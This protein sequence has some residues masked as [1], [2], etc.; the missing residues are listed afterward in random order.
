M[1]TNVF[2]DAAALEGPEELIRVLTQLSNC[3]S[4]LDHQGNFLV[5]YDGYVNSTNTVETYQG[6]NTGDPSAGEWD[7]PANFPNA[8]GVFVNPAAV[9]VV[10]DNEKFRIEGVAINVQGVWL[11]RPSPAQDQ[12]TFKITTLSPGDMAARGVIVGGNILNLQGQF[13][14]VGNV[15]VW[16][17]NGVAGDNLVSIGDQQ[18]TLDDS[19]TAPRV[20]GC[21]DPYA[22]DLV[23]TA[24]RLSYDG[25]VLDLRA[26]FT[27]AMRLKPIFDTS[28]AILHYLSYRETTAPSTVYGIRLTGEVALSGSTLKVRFTFGAT[29]SDIS[30]TGVAVPARVGREYPSGSCLAVWM[31]WDQ[32]TQTM[33]LNVLQPGDVGGSDTNDELTWS[34]SDGEH[35][36]SEGT[37]KNLTVRGENT[38]SASFYFDRLAIWNHRKSDSFVRYDFQY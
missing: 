37:S 36:L 26:D 10:N 22:V 19:G 38:P 18:L 23:S 15:L 12:D 2:Q 34:P 14:I 8:G 5:E 11:Q 7:Q 32:D 16:I 13:A 3:A 20:A 4:S 25:D 28:A 9:A 31:R 29:P 21:L 33:T 30:P 24:S 6:M 17:A 27:V 35:I 1:Y